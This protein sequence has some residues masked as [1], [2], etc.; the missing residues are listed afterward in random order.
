MQCGEDE[1]QHGYGPIED[2]DAEETGASTSGQNPDNIIRHGFSTASIRL[3]RCRHR[4]DTTSNG[5]VNDSPKPSSQGR[6]CRLTLGPDEGQAHGSTDQSKYKHTRRSKEKCDGNYT[7]VHVNYRRLAPNPR[8]WDE[9]GG[10]QIDPC[11]VQRHAM[12]CHQ[13]LWASKR[14]RLQPLGIG[15]RPG[16]YSTKAPSLYAANCKCDHASDGFFGRT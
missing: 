9:E 16:P 5:I 8:W 13:K 10:P 3:A 15:G 7:Y 1:V 12:Q 11:K 14:R 6:P 4:E 2:R